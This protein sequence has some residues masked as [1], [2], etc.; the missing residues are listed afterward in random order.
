MNRGP[1]LCPQ[2]QK[3]LPRMTLL[4]PSRLADTSAPVIDHIAERW[5]PRAFDTDFTLEEGALR[6]IF[7]AARWA[8]SASNTQPWRFVIARRGSEAFGKITANLMGF[9]QAWAGSASALVVNIAETQTADGNPQP[10]AVYDLGQAVAYLSLQAQSEGLHL[11]QM[12]GFD[13]DAIAAA[14]GLDERHSVISVTAIGRL[15]A[16]EQLPEPLAERET[17]PRTRLAV[18]ELVLVND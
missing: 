10:W 5:S 18:E 4:T 16:P 1:G 3:V 15:G 7:E 17:A 12:G 6:G 13:A 11:H 2:D 14:F 8:P 9:N